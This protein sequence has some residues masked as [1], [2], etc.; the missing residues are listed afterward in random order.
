MRQA[1]IDCELPIAFQQRFM[2]FIE[3]GSTFA[4]RVSW[5]VDQRWPR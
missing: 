5:P 2:P 4:Q 1:A 3:G